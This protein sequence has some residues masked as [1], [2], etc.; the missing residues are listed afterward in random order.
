LGKN[1]KTGVWRFGYVD[2]LRVHVRPGWD[3]QIAQRFA[4]AAAVETVLESIGQWRT[5]GIRHPK[6]G[7]LTDA[8]C[9]LCLSAVLLRKLGFRDWLYL[10]E[11]E[12]IA[13]LAARAAKV[14]PVM[15]AP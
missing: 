11:I 7:C 14:E 12:K 9:H 15:G 2:G 3:R 1:Q 5:L 8:W 13:G 10:G 6:N 4:K